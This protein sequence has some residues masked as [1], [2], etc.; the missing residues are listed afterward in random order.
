MSTVITCYYNIASKFSHDHYMSWIS[1]FMSIPFNSI[2]FCDKNSFDVLMSL[3]PENA[4]RKYR[5]VEMADFYV[6]RFDWIKDH[7][8][9]P[10]KS[11]HSPELYKIWA[12]KIFFVERAINENVYNT[13][14]FTWTDI[15]SFREPSRLSVFQGYPRVVNSS[16][17]TFLQLYEFTPEQAS[18]IQTVDNRFLYSNGIGGGIFTGRKDILLKF[19]DLY[20]E[21]IDEFD[22]NNIFKGKDQTLFAFIILRN[23]SLFNIVQS[24]GVRHYSKWFYLHYWLSD[25]FNPEMDMRSIADFPVTYICPDHDEKYKKRN[26]VTKSLL[27]KVGFRSI[28]HHKSGTNQYPKCLIEAT[29]NTLE[30]NLD[31]NPF[32]LVED[33]IAWTGINKIE[34]PPD[35]DAIY[36]GVSFCAGHPTE[37]THKLYCDL[38]EYS[39][40]ISRVLNMLS[41]HAILYI[42]K[43]YKQAVL[44]EMYKIR[45]IVY[46]TDVAI[47]RIQELYY[48]YT[49]NFPVFYQDDD[50][51]RDVT[52]IKFKCNYNQVF[53]EKI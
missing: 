46:N 14:Y 7:Q 40:D 13:D 43:R 15:G 29:I 6:S 36:F 1:N 16:C 10:E 22:K 35:A 25:N 38:W 30:A 4:T 41:T 32:L 3:Y 12:E 52:K 39:N 33:D 19:K 20:V 47:S 42:S 23:P 26:I 8:I 9:D 21:M 17:L 11:I 27:E 24:N 28:T 18:N 5:I 53:I 37:N 49:V 44:N 50:G 48:V 2:I 31:D 51:S 34:F 45:D